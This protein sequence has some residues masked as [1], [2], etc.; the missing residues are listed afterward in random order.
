[1]PH[2]PTN[3]QDNIQQSP[4]LPD[5]I[6]TMSFAD[7]VSQMPQANRIAGAAHQIV[8]EQTT[9]QNHP[10]AVYTLAAMNQLGHYLAGIPGRKNLIWFSGSFPAAL[11]DSSGTL[12]TTFHETMNLLAR[13]QVAV[14][15]MDARGLTNT[16]LSDVSASNYALNGGAAVGGDTDQFST[17]TA[18]EHSTMRRVATATG[19]K[20]YVNVNDLSQAIGEVLDHGS[21]YYT[22]VYTPTDKREDGSYRKIAVRLASGNYTLTYRDGYYSDSSTSNAVPS[23]DAMHAAMQRGAPD[24]S[25]IIFKAL[26]AASSATSDKLAEGNK[27]SP[28]TKP[29]YRLLTV[30]Y[31]ANPSDITMPE[32]PD[33]TRQVALD[34]VALVY[35]RE[36]YLFTQQSNTVNVFAKPAA[37]DQF[38][39]E[40][41][42]YQ[43]RIAVPAKGEYYL[44]V[45]IHDMI[46]DKV[47]AIEIPVASIATT[48][49]QSKSQPAK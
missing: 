37:I 14:Y 8:N 25:D 36:G 19:G 34:F 5:P 3:K 32:R 12:Q 22:L 20:A 2:H 26:L 47:G 9:Q 39:K 38:L 11:L 1:M 10:R 29:P 40:G 23:V 13:S 33:G 24:P 21:N 28:K 30:A 45:G 41:V 4:I 49:E 18:D 44:R 43:Q 7:A 27:A 15:P 48:P 6:G 46:G 42:R 16:P 31:A 35:D 17:R